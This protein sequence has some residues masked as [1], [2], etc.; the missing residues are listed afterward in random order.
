MSSSDYYRSTPVLQEDFGIVLMRQINVLASTGVQ[1]FI[2]SVI[3]YGRS[4]DG[5]SYEVTILTQSAEYVELE[6]S[7]PLNLISSPDAVEMLDIETVTPICLVASSF[8]CGQIFE[9]T[10]SAECSPDD[11]GYA[12]LSGNYKFGFTPQCIVDDDG[13][14][15][16]ACDTF[17]D[18][19]DGNDVV[20]ELNTSFVDDCS[21][22]LFDV[23]F[24]GDLVFYSDA[25]FAEA[26]TTE[27]APFVIGQDTVY[28]K[29]TVNTPDDPDGDI[30][31]FVE[32]SIEA[33]YVC[34]ADPDE[35]DLDLTSSIDSDAGTGGC[36]SSSI[37]A[38]GP[39]K[40]I[41][42]GALADYQGITLDAA[43]N[44]ATFSFLTF[45]TPRETIYVHVQ[46]LMTLQSESGR[47]RRRMLLQ[48]FSDSD[49]DSAG[50][51]AFQSYIASAS[52]QE[53]ETTI[54]PLETDGAKA[55]SVGFVPA[56]FVFIAG[57]FV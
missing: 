10:V 26:V 1:L 15:E 43:G 40:V 3:G 21:V 32:V 37:D 57:I 46:L 38:D 23:T 6:M 56:L 16:P 41:G 55:I 20:L 9:M 19:L 22:D 12:D 8:T 39:Y 47:R 2:P 24:E 11:D 34:T 35:D 49:S 52:V 5:V 4:D 50:G 44:E 42:T 48:S 13:N 14:T 54:A 7:D 30:Y 33:V 45:D 25:A 51:N 31:E 27:S 18:S 36:L 53:E 29:V 17:M 28:G